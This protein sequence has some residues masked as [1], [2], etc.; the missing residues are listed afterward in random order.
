MLI[1]SS[2]QTHFAMQ[3]RISWL[4]Y[5]SDLPV[6]F[7]R[8]SS[9]SDLPYCAAKLSHVSLLQSVAVEFHGHW[10][11]GIADSFANVSGWRDAILPIPCRRLVRRY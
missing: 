11:R 4:R 2:V 9:A 8:Q 1:S 6:R 7:S 3:L 5:Q 10:Y